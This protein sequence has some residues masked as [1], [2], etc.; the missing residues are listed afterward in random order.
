MIHSHLVGAEPYIQ[1]YSSKT[2]TP[3][4]NTGSTILSDPLSDKASGESINNFEVN[5]AKNPP[6]NIIM[7]IWNKITGSTNPQE[8][9]SVICKVPG[10]YLVGTGLQIGV[11]GSEA[12]G[13]L[14][15]WFELNDTPISNSNSRQYI[16]QN[17]RTTLL[18]N[19]FLIKLKEGDKFSIKYTASGPDIGIIAFKDL[20]NNEPDIFSFGASIV[21]V[22]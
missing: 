15:S 2:Q 4:L 22:D 20:P 14:D 7:R 17:S 12:S 18:T 16:N 19:T 13:Y 1:L 10:V 8:I 5:L 21:K 11:I 9:S 6:L 3:D